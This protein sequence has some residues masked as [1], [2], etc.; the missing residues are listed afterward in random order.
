M[1]AWGGRFS[2]EPDADAAD[3]GR[4]IDVDAELALDDIA[5]SL[6]HV[7]GLLAA[8]LLTDAEAAAIRDGLRALEVEIRAGTIDWDPALEDIHLNIEMA[9][10]AR[11]GPVAGKLHTG[12]SRNDQ[13]ATDLRLWLKR[14][15][16]AIDEAV[17]G[18]EQALVRQGLGHRDAAMPGHTHIQ[19]AQPVLF[20]HH[21]LAYVEMLERDRGRFADA[22]RRADVS[23]LGSG[24]IAGA[25]FALDREAVAAELGFTGVT[26]N[27]ID[28]VGDRD[29][30]VETLAAAALAMTHLSR[31]SEELVWWSNPAFGFLRLADAWSTGSSMMPNKRNPDTAELVRGR[32]ARVDGHLVAALTL[33]KGLPAGY[34]RDLQE[35]KPGLF[36]ALRVL[37][38][39]L[40]VMTGAVATLVV[41]ES[42]MRAASSTGFTTATAV[43]DALVERG[44]PFREAHHLVGALVARAE[45]ARAELI[46]L[47]DADVRAI[48]GASSDATAASLAADAAVPGALRA[49]AS[50]ENALARPDVI[51]GTA[52]RRVHAELAAAAERLGLSG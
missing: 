45:G 40:R 52:P 39:S 2:A 36:D 13:V 25:G 16:A 14:R 15:L 42:R 18:L 28:A 33:L 48:L 9:L 21:L 10:A 35:D 17:V 12:R 50:L 7:G 3:F 38:S 41:D 32:T 47:T 20:A 46:G 4:S 6:A 26:H 29:F 34:Q 49:A 31:L 51:G 30:V 8:G 43:A 24:A 19:P 11:I 44:V 23:P 27:S 37:Q 22:L 1:Q 5:G